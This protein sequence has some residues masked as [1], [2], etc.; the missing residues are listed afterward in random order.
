MSSYRISQLAHKQRVICVSPNFLCAVWMLSS[1]MSG[2]SPKPSRLY[3][4]V[5]IKLSQLA[6]SFTSKEVYFYDT[7]AQRDFSCQY[8]LQV[9]SLNVCF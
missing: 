7:L 2:S 3:S 8:K 1:Q 5:F 9:T 6:V 4:D